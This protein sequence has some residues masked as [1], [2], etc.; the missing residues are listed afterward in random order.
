[1]IAMGARGDCSVPREAPPVPLYTRPGPGCPRSVTCKSWSLVLFL[2]SLC[3]NSF[4]VF[5]LSE[6]YCPSTPVRI[7]DFPCRENIP[8]GL[9]NVAFLMGFE[10]G[11]WALA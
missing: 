2:F 6:R 8:S 10:C 7:L 1:M 11:T 5:C 4:L 9:H 3:G